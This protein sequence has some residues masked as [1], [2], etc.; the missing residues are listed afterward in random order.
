M[1]ENIKIN[2][3][4]ENERLEMAKKSAQSLPDVP[5]LLGWTPAQFKNSITRCLFDNKN[6]FYSYI[7]RIANEIQVGVDQIIQ[8][9]YNIGFR[10]EN[11]K[12]IFTTPD[13]VQHEISIPSNDFL[14]LQIFNHNISNESHQDIRLE[15]KDLKNKINEIFSSDDIDLDT[16]QEVVDFIKENRDYI[17][18]KVGYDDIIDN[19]ETASSKKVLSAN[20]GARIKSMIDELRNDIDFGVK[21]ISFSEIDSLFK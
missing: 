15:I 14:N 3:I 6:S 5:S 2:V 13:G 18:L 19:L 4:S 1:I 16:L 20:Q 7:N 9:L 11:G 10:Y 17:D 21:E 8:Y 12:L